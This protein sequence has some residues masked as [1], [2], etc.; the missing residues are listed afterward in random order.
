MWDTASPHCLS[1]RFAYIDSNGNEVPIPSV[2]ALALRIELGAIS[3]ETQLYDAQADQWG[4][5][6]THEIYHTLSRASE[7]DDGFIAPPPVGPPPVAAPAPVEPSVTEPL[8]AE[9]PAEEDLAAA[10][11]EE[12]EA[13]VPETP[14]PLGAVDLGLTLAEPPEIEDGEDGGLDLDLSLSDGDAEH[15]AGLTL[16]DPSP[17]EGG[18]VAVDDE[19]ASGLAMDFGGM[20]LAPALDE[21]PDS[22]SM[23]LASPG[24]DAA[25]PAGDDLAPEATGT[26]DFGGMEGGLE[27]EE[28]F[29]PPDE[30]PPMDLAGGGTEEPVGDF[31]GDMELE[32]T[33]DFGSGGFAMDDGGALDL[34]APMSEFSP[35]DPP[36]WM[37]GD[38]AS[39]GPGDVL[40][41]SAVGG[42][43]EADVPL[44]DRRTPKNK[45]SAPKRPRRSL[46]GPLIG[47]VVVVAISVGLYATWPVINDRL[48]AGPEDAPQAV[49]M[50]PISAELMPQ[51]R[52]A[53]EASLAAAFAGVRQ[54]WASGGAVVA[55]PP[56]W[57]AGIYL[58]RASEYEEAEVFW[59]GVGDLLDG[60]RAI[61]L[62][63]FDA[64][65]AG[66]MSSRGV[67]AADAETM[68]ARADS[69]FV[70]AAEAREATYVQLETLVDAALRLHQ[71]LVAN[72]A[73]IA[74]VP[75][76]SVTTDPVLEVNPASEE[77]GD[78][79]G[80]LISAVTGALGA[81]G[82]R[83][84]VTA[85]GLWG[86][87]L[88]RIQ[89]TGIQ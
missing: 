38:G 84:R 68:R 4:P 7:S 39:T 64:A 33:M 14:E 49:F 62:T 2:D 74:Y 66:D 5:A 77:I 50:P 19:D 87:V 28:T 25:A 69:G 51:M 3:E 41:F 13:A 29:E 78:A 16:A 40:D 6:H 12:L 63:D 45:P 82:Y 56:D 76:S 53:A 30:T 60:A 21:A 88:Q 81:L 34:E 52:V 55:P 27:L 24:P 47:A 59:N 54:E 23:D 18:E 35:Q 26:F 37:G 85:D 71:F 46:T 83:D 65:F 72:E 80:E 11:I 43:S 22:A 15:D 48:R 36:S 61:D 9:P 42:E 89:D 86:A 70:A 67:S 32:T 79:M 10:E 44:R 8:V 75:A 73:N 1:M 17:H 57:L 20:D 31:G 58:A